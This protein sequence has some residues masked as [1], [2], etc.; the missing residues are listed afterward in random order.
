MTAIEKCW[1]DAREAAESA[2]EKYSRDILSA[3][4]LYA[5][6]NQVRAVRETDPPSIRDGMFLVTGAHIPRNATVEQ[7]TGWIFEH[8]KR[9]PYLV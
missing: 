8:L 9:A 6:A 7:N 3:C 1:T 4:Y 2:F 5:G